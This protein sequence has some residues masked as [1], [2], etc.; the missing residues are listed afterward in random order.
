MKKMQRWLPGVLD[1]ERNKNE[2][3]VNRSAK[4]NQEKLVWSRENVAMRFLKD[5]EIAQIRNR[6]FNGRDYPPSI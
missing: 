2:N 4:E 6:G 3:V 1:T 5:P